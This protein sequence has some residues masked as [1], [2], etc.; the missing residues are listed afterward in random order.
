MKYDRELFFVSAL[1]HDLGLSALAKGIE[2]FEIEGADIAKEFLATTG[3]NDVDIDVVWDAVALH[4][5]A[6]IPTRKRPE[7]ALV[8][9]GAGID[10]GFIPLDVALSSQLPEILE[11]WPRLNFKREFPTLFVALAKKNPRAA[12]SHV[13]ADICERL[14]P[15]FQ[16]LHTCDVIEHA[17]FSD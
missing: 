5:T 1:L 3:M 9:I 17:S 6:G 13:T 7:V 15:G 16:R 12:S 4:T 8:Q 11:E 10:V 2:R 14:L